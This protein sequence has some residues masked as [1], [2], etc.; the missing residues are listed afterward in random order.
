M[1]VESN[2]DEEAI[3]DVVSIS[4]HAYVKDTV[5]GGMAPE[6]LAITEGTGERMYAGKYGEGDAMTPQE[7]R[8]LMKSAERV[9]EPK[10]GESVRAKCHCGG[11]D[12]MVKRAE[13]ESEPPGVQRRIDE[14]EPH[15]YEAKFCACRSCRLSCGFSL[16]PW[17]YCSPKAVSIAA[18]GAVVVV[19]LS[20]MEQGAN[21]GL[22]LKHYESSKGVYRSFCGGCGAIV[23]YY[24]A[25]EERPDVLDVSVGLLRAESGS[26]AREWVRWT[27]GKVS[28]AEECVDKSQLECIQRNGGDD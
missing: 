3:K 18:S 27:R 15:K 4:G 11:V 24:R 22:K 5:D 19:G 14:R 16:Q 23:F 2:G 25:G 28:H 12:L 1:E 8:A 21:H 6:L 17:F 13:Y 9:D 26:M 7:L 10:E 20:A